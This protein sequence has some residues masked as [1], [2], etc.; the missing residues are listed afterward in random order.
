MFKK[1]IKS[2]YYQVKQLP[3]RKKPLMRGSPAYQIENTH[4]FQLSPI[5]ELRQL[6]LHK[7]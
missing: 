7:I 2:H 5:E 6:A 4:S 3:P 1:L